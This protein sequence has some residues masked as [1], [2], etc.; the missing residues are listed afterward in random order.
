M[1][2]NKFFNSEIILPVTLFIFVLLISIP[3]AYLLKKDT[4]IDHLSLQ[5]Q[6]LQSYKNL[7]SN[8][9]LYT[10]DLKK[11][12][13]FLKNSRI[14]EL[15][16]KSIPET[17]AFILDFLHEFLTDNQPNTLIHYTFGKTKPLKNNLVIIPVDIEFICEKDT[18]LYMIDS[19]ENNDFDIN[20]DHFDLENRFSSGV[21]GTM[22]L[23]F[24]GNL[25]G[26][27]INPMSN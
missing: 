26:A 21:Y 5:R 8:K 12:K 6:K 10:Q 22:R 15:E 13:T 4:S 25:P 18:L 17:H 27:S 2:K 14:K 23:S 19:I 1:N 3:M 20:I 9:K 7:S 11:F 16:I 24:W